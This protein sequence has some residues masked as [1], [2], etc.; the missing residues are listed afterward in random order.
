M[1]LYVLYALDHYHANMSNSPGRLSAISQVS[2]NGSSTPLVPNLT[3]GFYSLERKKQPHRGNT[4]ILLQQRSWRGNTLPVTDTPRPVSRLS[5]NH[6]AMATGDTVSLRECSSLWRGLSWQAR[7]QAITAWIPPR[8][9]V[10]NFGVSE[11]PGRAQEWGAWQY[12]YDNI[13]QGFVP[14]FVGG[15]LML[16][17]KTALTGDRTVGRCCSH[18][19][20]TGDGHIIH[21][22]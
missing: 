13:L 5:K 6:E 7:L 9:V 14:K 3:S 2:E 12:S 8:I 21:Q 15:Q 4:V 10:D 20:A 16:Q 11:H 18:M 1:T 19:D 17:K 22:L